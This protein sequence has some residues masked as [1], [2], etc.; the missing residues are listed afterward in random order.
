M[1]GTNLNCFEAEGEQRG[2]YSADLEGKEE[3]DQSSQ[4]N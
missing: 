1:D 4:E 2:Y 3:V